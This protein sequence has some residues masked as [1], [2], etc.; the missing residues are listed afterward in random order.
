M[1]TA[2]LYSPPPSLG[3]PT[4]IAL[5]TVGVV[6][7]GLWT[8]ALWLSPDPQGYGTHRQ[9][10]LPPCSIVQW[11]G[12]RCP[13]CGM[14]TSWSLLIRGRIWSATEANAGGMLLGLAA[15]A[16]APWT[17][18]S[19]WRGRW[20]GCVPDERILAL[21]L[22]VILSVAMIDWGLRRL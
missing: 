13:A 6:L 10:G 12:Q 3:I 21:L 8:V 22:G 11:T 17:L 20:W 5:G 19:A 1:S 16:A 18:L 4:R 14:T 15:L 9:L 7:V 2:P